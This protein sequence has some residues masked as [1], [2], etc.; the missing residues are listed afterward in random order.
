MNHV[1]TLAPQHFPDFAFSYPGLCDDQRTRKRH[2]N[3]IGSGQTSS[4]EEGHFVP[5]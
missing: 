2:W 3:R 1:E 4:L 5:L